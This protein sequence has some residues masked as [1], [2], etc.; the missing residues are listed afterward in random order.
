MVEGSLSSE[1]FVLVVQLNSEAGWTKFLL[2]VSFLRMNGARTDEVLRS[3]HACNSVWAYFILPLFCHKSAP[4]VAYYLI[5]ITVAAELINVEKN[6]LASVN[7][8]II[9]IQP[10]FKFI[11][12]FYMWLSDGCKI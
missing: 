8:Y 6:A 11:V 3:R 4:G 10:L 9:D 1:F 5:F 12:R 2:S 7:I